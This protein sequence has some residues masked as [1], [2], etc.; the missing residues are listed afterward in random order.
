MACAT[1]DKPDLEIEVEITVRVR[2]RSKGLTRNVSRGQVGRQLGA[3]EI[4][5]ACKAGELRPAFRSQLA[6]H[7]ASFAR[8]QLSKMP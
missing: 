1:A 4:R 8:V 5:H 7:I 3:S 6:D 2:S